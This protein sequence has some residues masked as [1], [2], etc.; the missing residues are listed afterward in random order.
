MP[1]IDPDAAPSALIYFWMLVPLVVGALQI[2]CLIHA[3]VKRKDSY[4]YYLLFFM[5]FVGAAAY[6]FTQ[7]LPTLRY[8]SLSQ[9]ELPFFQKMKIKQLESKLEDCDSVDNR[10]E[11]AE[12]YAKFNRD[13]EALALI[14]DC[15]TGPCK[16]SPDLI[17]TYAVVQFQNGNAAEALTQLDKLDAAGAKNKRKDRQ[18]LRARVLDALDKSAD[19]EARFKEAIKGFD[20]EEARYWYADFLM[21]QKR[22]ADAIAL[23]EE[24]MKYYKKSESLY[25]RVE[26]YWYSA[27]KMV[28]NASRKQQASKKVNG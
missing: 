27:L 20:G 8:T 5:P 17:F 18:L 13:E 9:I 10:V 15:M 24:G 28:A 19:A 3:I 23:A 1:D 22:Y 16:D 4:W 12:V 6:F 7:I 26:S 14:K 21:R 11:L 25:R 2:A